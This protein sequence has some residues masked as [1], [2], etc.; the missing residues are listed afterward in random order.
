M[1]D[2]AKLDFHWLPTDALFR[3]RTK[4]LWCDWWF[5]R[6]HSY[7]MAGVGRLHGQLTWWRYN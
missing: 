6:S 5:S 1:I 7:I 3:G 2:E 4:W